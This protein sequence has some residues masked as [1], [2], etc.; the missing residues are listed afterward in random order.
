MWQIKFLR[1]PA[2]PRGPLAWWRVGALLLW[3]ILAGSLGLS[4]LLIY[5]STFQTLNEA[6]SIVV[7]SATPDLDSIDIEKYELA[8]AIVD[9]KTKGPAIPRLV[10]DIF[11]FSSS[12]PAAEPVSTSSLSS[13]H[14][15]TSAVLPR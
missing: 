10:R 2:W 3:G 13:P 8:E 15:A 5:Q 11:S 14:G 9:N 7:L 1:L 4:S 6:N 12:S